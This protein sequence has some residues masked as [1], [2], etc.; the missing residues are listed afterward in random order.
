L[1][2]ADNDGLPGNEVQMGTNPLVETIGLANLKRELET[3]RI[4]MYALLAT[5]LIF[6]ITTVYFMRKRK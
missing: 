4:L 5:T 6:L 1:I 2:A 3:T